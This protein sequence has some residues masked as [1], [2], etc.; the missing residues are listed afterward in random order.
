MRN[1]QLASSSQNGQCISIEDYNRTPN[2]SN[3]SFDMNNLI[4][5][6]GSN[7]GNVKRLKLER[8]SN[9]LNPNQTWYIGH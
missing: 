8:C 3:N 9:S 7:N 4:I 1:M 6:K 2:N 5:Q